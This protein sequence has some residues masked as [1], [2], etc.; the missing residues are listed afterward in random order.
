M[1]ERGDGVGTYETPPNPGA[2]QSAQP[3]RWELNLRKKVTVAFGA[4]AT[5]TVIAGA[6]AF[7]CTNLATLNL[8]SSAGKAGDTVTVTGSSFNVNSQNVAN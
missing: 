1:P 4:A 5:A 7:A 3:K 2:V 6:A 8:S